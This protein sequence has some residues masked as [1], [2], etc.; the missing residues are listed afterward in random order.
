[1]GRE[2]NEVTTI[3]LCANLMFRLVLGELLR[4][5]VMGVVRVGVVG[6][7]MIYSL[8]VCS[9]GRD[10]SHSGGGDEGGVAN[11]SVVV[12]WKQDQ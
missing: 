9:T 8:S 7:G 5:L 11:S 3:L 6:E 2:K 12:Q 10:P 1:M 4:P